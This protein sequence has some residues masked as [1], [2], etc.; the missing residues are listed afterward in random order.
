MKRLFILLLLANLVVFI[1]LIFRGY[2]FSQIVAGIIAALTLAVIIYLSFTK[3][4]SMGMIADQDLELNF[5]P[6]YKLHWWNF[7]KHPLTAK[8]RS[9]LSVIQTE[10]CNRV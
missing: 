6:Q 3:T 4:I 8:A 1:K 9:K 7:Y 5:E 10:N 2:V